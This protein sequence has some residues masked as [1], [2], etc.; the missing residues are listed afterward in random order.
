MNFDT[1]S[2]VLNGVLFE[3]KVYFGLLETRGRRF[4][5]ELK[6]EILIII[7]HLKFSHLDRELFKLLEH[8]STD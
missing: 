6:K 5:V 8:F 1:A 2:A 7:A 4:F 3:I